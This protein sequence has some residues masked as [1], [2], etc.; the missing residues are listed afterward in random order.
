MNP[1][2]LDAKF[3]NQ[4][5][6]CTS[7]S[8]REM[9]NHDNIISGKQYEK[10]PGGAG[11]SGEFLNRVSYSFLISG[12]VETDIETFRIMRDQVLIL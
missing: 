12:W 7:T 11:S 9:S 5:E 2:K 8:I 6:V 1:E 3:F 4:D 10:K